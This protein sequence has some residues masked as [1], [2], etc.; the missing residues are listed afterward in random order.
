MLRYLRTSLA[1][2]AVLA[3]LI[4]LPVDTAEAAVREAGI[5]GPIHEASFFQGFFEFLSSMWTKVGEI[6]AEGAVLVEG[7]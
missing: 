2:L 5:S 1:V 6:A 7:G 4:A 3:C